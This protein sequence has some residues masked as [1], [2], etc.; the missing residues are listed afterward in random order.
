MVYHLR[1]ECAN[2]E[3]RFKLFLR[4]NAAPRRIVCPRC[5][6]PQPLR[7]EPCDSRWW[8]EM[9]FVPAM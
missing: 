6:I 3:W 8:K 7:L 1:A 2:C 4:L 5:H 9:A